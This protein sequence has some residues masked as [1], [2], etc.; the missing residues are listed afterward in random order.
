MSLCE[1]YRVGFGTVAA[2]S[3]PDV[4]LRDREPALELDGEHL[5]MFL[6]PGHQIHTLVIIGSCRNPALLDER[7]TQ[8]VALRASMATELSFI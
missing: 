4:L 7:D 6:V 1:S 3:L 2:N 8:G 5:A